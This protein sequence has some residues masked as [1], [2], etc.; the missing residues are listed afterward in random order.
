MNCAAKGFLLAGL[1]VCTSGNRLHSAS[2]TAGVSAIHTNLVDHWVTNTTKVELQVNRFVTE[3]HTNWVTLTQT[4]VVN[5]FATNVVTKNH[6]N[7]LVLDSVL[8][9]LVQLYRTN[10]QTLHLTNWTTVLSFKT[11]WVTKPLT[12]V[13][14]I[15]LSKESTPAAVPAGQVKPELGAEPLLLQATR[16]PRSVINNQ[17]EVQLTVAWAHGAELPLQVQQWRIEREDGS[18]LCFGQ[19]PRFQR[20][21]PA[22][23]YKVLV[24]AQRDVKSP[25]V[26]ALGTLTVGVQE[27]L[28]EQRPARSNSSI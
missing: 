3:Y 17:I 28:I 9:N 16:T 21:L 7:T 10:L 24:R 13:V 15:E 25:L 23:T 26:A 5:L 20:S 19:E 14:E 11:N 18:I 6:T 4:N 1:I 8:T 22:G 2:V 27:I 12:N